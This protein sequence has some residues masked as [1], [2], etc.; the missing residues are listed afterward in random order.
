MIPA[1]TAES[2]TAANTPPRFFGGFVPHGAAPGFWVPE[3]VG[4]L[5]GRTAIH[6]EADGAVPQARE[7]FD[8]PA[9][10][11][12]RTASGGKRCRPL[13]G[14][15]IPVCAEAAQDC[16]CGR[17]RR[18]RPSTR[19]IAAKYGQQTL[20]PVGGDLGG[21]PGFGFVAIAAK[22]TAASIPT[23]SPGLRRPRRCPWS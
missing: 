3:Q 18:G 8:R 22:A 21:R 7:Y 10:A 13:G 20:L 2:K 14:R 11:L 16:R 9:F 5:P 23:R 19:I 17:V 12:L 15:R 1:F 6:V 4:A